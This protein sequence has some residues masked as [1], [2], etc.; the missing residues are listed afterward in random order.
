MTEALL[1]HDSA[2]QNSLGCIFH[3]FIH[4]TDNKSFVIEFKEWK[5]IS[6]KVRFSFVSN[7]NLESIIRE[8]FYRVF[9][10]FQGHK[11]YTWT[12][13]QKDKQLNLVLELLNRRNN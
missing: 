3:I 5:W 1:R 4:G 12:H 6:Y 11:N 2:Y 8:A 7:N 9:D 13:H 10:Y